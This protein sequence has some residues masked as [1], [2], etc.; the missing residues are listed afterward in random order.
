MKLKLTGVIE[1]FADDSAEALAVRLDRL[2]HCLAWRLLTRIPRDSGIEMADLIQAGNVGLAQ[3]ALTFTA[4]QGF[5]LAGYAK[6][7]IRG[8]ML[9]TVRRHAGRGSYPAL[10]RV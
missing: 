7:R 5:K 8:E 9:D 1:T 3:A 10:R 4:G 6:F 2:V